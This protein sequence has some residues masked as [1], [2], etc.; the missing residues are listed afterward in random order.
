MTSPVTSFPGAS[1]TGVPAGTT[2]K[3]SGPIT[4]TTAGT[5]IDGLDISGSVTVRAANV[6]IKNSKIHG[7]G[8]GDGVVVSGGNVTVQDS[9]IYNFENGIGYSNWTALRVNIHSNTGD[10]VKIG[11]NTL[12]QDSWLH[13]FTPGKGAHTDGAQMQD[14]STNVTLR[15]N[16]I[17]I[18]YNGPGN[19]AI[20]I[21]PIFGPS[22]NGPVMIEDN[23]LS[24]G[25]FTIFIIGGA[26][27][28]GYTVS[29]ITV[30]NN[31]F[32]PEHE[33]GPVQVSVPVTWTNNKTSD[34]KTLNP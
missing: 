33:Y 18:P 6:V 2:L 28:G 31:V 22:T 4:V 25:G 21:Q 27:A 19:G 30:R 10:G 14:G 7:S 15:H 34:G 23:Y 29:G 11:S 8:T 3:A 9:E 12:L 13:D 26:N 16:T 1:N 17:A 20:Y 24:G 5:V 32:G